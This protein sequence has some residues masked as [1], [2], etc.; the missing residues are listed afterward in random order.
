MTLVKPDAW[1]AFEALDHL[2]LVEMRPPISPAG[3]M[4]PFYALL[5]GSE[6]PPLHEQ[7]CRA[8]RPLHGTGARVLV[9]TG[10]V[11]EVRFPKG[12]I[13]GPLGSLVLARALAMLGWESTVIIDAEA[14]APTEAILALMDAPGVR[15]RSGDF[16]DAA[17]ARAY[18][19]EFAAVVAVEKLG[20]NAKGVRHLV[21]GKP[22]DGGDQ[23]ADDYVLGAT[24]AG[25]L[26]IGIGDNGNEIG[27][28]KLPREA[29]G[30]TARGL[31]CGC[32]C[33]DGIMSRTACDILLPAAVSNVGCYTVAAALAL[34]C[35]RAD[36][37]VSGEQV[38]AWIESGL[39]AGLRAGA[40][41]DTL[42]RG[43]DG[44]PTRYCAAHAELI[45]GVVHQGLLGAE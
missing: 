36:L 25:A 27:F 40:V 5:R 31:E 14:A 26:T 33:G 21:G 1:P 20:R 22:C 43:D 12:E 28:G 4:G 6:D 9:V 38:R 17:S 24:A 35:G 29:G 10:L 23:Y 3:V 41:A 19:A 7:I 39:D 18:G 13:D 30:V 34:D 45:A 2:A 8:L 16:Q 32:P 44:I 15:V 42:F 11:D 37:A